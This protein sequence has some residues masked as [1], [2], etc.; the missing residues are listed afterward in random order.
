MLEHRLSKKRYSAFFK[1]GLDQTLDLLKP[2]VLV[3]AG[4]NTHACVR[5]TAIDAYQRD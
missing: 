1:T 4:V 5:M 3:L 2:V